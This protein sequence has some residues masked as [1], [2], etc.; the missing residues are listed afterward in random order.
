MGEWLHRRN[1]GWLSSW[2]VISWSNFA[3]SS[4]RSAHVALRLRLF[5]I[6]H[7]SPGCVYP[8]SQDAK[9]KTGMES[10]KRKVILLNASNME[11]YPVYP[12]A[13]IQVPA[14]ARLYDVEIICQD[15]LG[16]HLVDWEKLLHKLL[17]DHDPAMILITLRNTDS[18]VAADYDPES[19]NKSQRKAY[20]PIERT[21]KLIAAIREITDKKIAVGGFAFSLLADDLIRYLQPDFGVF[22]GPDGFFEHFDEIQTGAHSHVPNLLYFQDGDLVSNDRCFYPPYRGTEY[23]SSKVKERMSF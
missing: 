12:Y 14:V 22:G 8:E 13:F 16:V 5:G 1:Q 20:F 18:M 3:K 2:K 23:T 9:R 15:L 6:M 7:S 17:S 4:S 21:R 11:S 10:G 19:L